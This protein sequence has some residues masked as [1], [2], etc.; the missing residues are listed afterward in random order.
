MC[1]PLRTGY[2]AA[3]RALCAGTG[4]LSAVQ[5]GCDE[6]WT[7]EK[8]GRRLGEGDQLTAAQERRGKR[9]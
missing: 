9:Q 5:K 6:R 8:Q 7:A 2:L 3:F 1:M 4:A